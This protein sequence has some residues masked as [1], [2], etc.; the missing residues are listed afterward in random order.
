MLSPLTPPE[1]SQELVALLTLVQRTG[2]VAVVFPSPSLGDL[3]MITRETFR[4]Q[5]RIAG[6]PRGGYTI[7]PPIPLYDEELH[8]LCAQYVEAS[9]QERAELR[10]SLY[11]RQFTLFA[12]GTRNDGPLFHPADY[13]SRILQFCFVYVH[14]PAEAVPSLHATCPYLHLTPVREICA[15]L[16]SQVGAAQDVQAEVDPVVPEQLRIHAFLDVARLTSERVTTL[17]TPAPENSGGTAS[18]AEMPHTPNDV[19]SV[20]LFQPSAIGDDSDSDEASA[21]EDL[22]GSEVVDAVHDARARYLSADDFELVTK[23][24]TFYIGEGGT[25]RVVAVYIPRGVAV[26]VCHAAA[27]V[28]EP[29]ATKKNMRAAVNGGVPPDTGI[30]GYYDYLN[31]PTKYKCRETEYMR[32]HRSELSESEPLVKRLDTLYREVAPVHYRLQQM[33]IPAEYQMYDTVFSTVTVNR[34]FRTAVHTDRGDFRSGLGVVAVINGKFEGCH[35]VIEDIKKA[36]RLNVGDVL[37]FDTSLTHGNTEVVGAAAHWYR[38]SVVCYLRTGLLSSA[39]EMERRTRLNKLIAQRVRNV[40]AHLDAVNINGADDNLPPLFVPTGLSRHLAPEQFAALGF[41]AERMKKGNGCVVAMRMGLGKT[42]VALTLCFSHLHITPHADVLVITPKQVISHWVEE[43]AKWARYGLQLSHFVAS[44]GLNTLQFES[45]ISA[46]VGAKGNGRAR[47]GHVFVINGEY[48]ASF[49]RRVKGFRPTLLIVDEGHRVA[50]KG[51]KLSDSLLRLGC[52]V[53]IVLSGTP[54]QND[55][56]E[57]YRLVGW[58]NKEVTKVLPPQ[59]FLQLADA[60]NKYVEG[61][62]DGNYDD[63]VRAQEYIQDWMCGFVFRELKCDLPPLHDYIL[64]CGTSEAQDRYKRAREQES[65]EPRTALTAAEHWPAHLAT[66]PACYLAFSTSSYKKLQSGWPGKKSTEEPAEDESAERSPSLRL[67]RDD[68]EQLKGYAEAVENGRVEDFIAHSGKLQV[69]AHIVRRVQAKNEKLIIFSTYVGTQDMIHR[70]L[71]GMRVNAFTIRGRDAQDRRRQALQEFRDDP[72]LTA[73][74]LSTKIAAYGLDITAANHVILFDT[75]W[76][77]QLDAQAI[78]RAY[79]RNQSKEVTVYRLISPTEDQFV[80]HR[81]VRKLALFNCIFHQRTSRE[82]MPEELEDCTE[83]ETDPERREF[84]RSLKETLLAGGSPS[85]E[86]V[87]RYEERIRESD[88][89]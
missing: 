78:A 10:N 74:V 33:A 45:Q 61:E 88:S 79:R 14:A 11:M 16:R 8:A 57:L 89:M 1:A 68:K 64:I 19:A 49:L 75:W 50:S 15:M 29:A 42:L 56:G 47:P 28:L 17:Q 80:V 24:G 73:L 30:V 32:N 87:Y 41:I 23:A 34:N 36:F 71:S 38:T 86:K 65:A 83:T 4:R 40:Q 31:H 21:L 43:R 63:A 39:A 3:E 6:I 82:A 7:L 85:L 62:K 52:N 44:D 54:L 26:D 60:I 59:R 35:L 77:P 22:T 51:S 12:Y 25:R 81:H 37:F 76:N 48:L 27:R 72:N 46:Y 2:E 66:H 70:T 13:V 58:V 67:N 5:L 84:W 9:D 55:A 69:L 53:R 18:S 20:D